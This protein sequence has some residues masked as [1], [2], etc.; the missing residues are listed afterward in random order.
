LNDQRRNTSIASSNLFTPSS[1]ARTSYVCRVCSKSFSSATRHSR[2]E[3]F[4]FCRSA[5]ANHR[6]MGGFRVFIADRKFH[7]SECDAAFFTI[8]SRTRH[9]KRHLFSKHGSSTVDW[10]WTKLWWQKGCVERDTY[11]TCQLCGKVFRYIP[12]LRVHLQCH[13][14]STGDWKVWFTGFAVVMKQLTV[15]LNISVIFNR[16]SV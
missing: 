9:Q 10:R 8:P 15:I 1:V 13:G 16:D 14:Y 12:C 2:H 6:R 3:S 7:C 11:P 5:S 4:H